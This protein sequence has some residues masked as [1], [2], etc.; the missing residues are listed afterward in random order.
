MAG[1]AEALE[2]ALIPKQRLVALVLDLVVSDELR[3]IAFYL[4]ASDH[5][6]CEEI[7]DQHLHPQLLPACRLVPA[8]P[9]DRLVA[10]AKP[11]FLVS[12][13][14]PHKGLDRGDQRLD[15]LEL[16]HAGRPLLSPSLRLAWD[17][18]P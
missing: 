8:A 5:L 1:L 17:Y 6:T 18:Q 2:I 4:A 10:L 11:G 3:R 14:P 16:S 15:G 13:H 7:A 12:R 9:S